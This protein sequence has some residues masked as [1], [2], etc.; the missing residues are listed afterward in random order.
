MKTNQTVKTYSIISL[1]LYCTTALAWKG[2]GEIKVM[3]QNQYLDAGLT[4]LLTANSAQF[5]DV[6]VGSLQKIAANRFRDRVQRLTAKIAKEVPI[7]VALH[8]WLMRLGR[9]FDNH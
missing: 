6:L 2:H 8:Y 1:L 7:L 3:T 5:N 4:P 9:L